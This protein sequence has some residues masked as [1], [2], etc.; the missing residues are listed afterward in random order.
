MVIV[1]TKRWKEIPSLVLREDDR[2]IPRLNSEDAR[3]VLNIF[4]KGCILIQ[5]YYIYIYIYLY[6]LLKK[7]EVN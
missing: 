6:N 1:T 2:S 4:K 3:F 7:Y 5:V